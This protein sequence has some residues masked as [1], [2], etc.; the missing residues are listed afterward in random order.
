VLH[1]LGLIP[2]SKPL[3]RRESTFRQSLQFCRH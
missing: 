1:R 2:S 3:I